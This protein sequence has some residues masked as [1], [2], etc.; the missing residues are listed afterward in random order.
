MVYSYVFTFAVL[1]TVMTNVC[2]YFYWHRPKKQ[3]FWPEWG[4]FILLSCATVLLL[5]APLK[6]LVVNICMQS[7]R[8]NGFDSTIEH[9]LDLAYMP[10]FGTRHQQFYTSLGYA[11]MLWGTAMQ[12]DLGGRIV[13]TFRTSYA[14]AAPKAAFRVSD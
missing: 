5:I 8:Q 6:N 13:H 14:K 9:V 1:M 12:V 10:M 3:T 7:F 4:P 11:F 2:Q